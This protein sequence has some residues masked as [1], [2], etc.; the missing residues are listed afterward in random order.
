MSQNTIMLKTLNGKISSG[1]VFLAWA[2][3]RRMGG[4]KLGRFS[5]PHKIENKIKKISIIDQEC[6]DRL[7]MMIGWCGWWVVWEKGEVDK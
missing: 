4:G 7:S 6:Q 2:Q 3:G 1:K 5:G